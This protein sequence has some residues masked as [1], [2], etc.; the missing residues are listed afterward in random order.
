MAAGFTVKRD[1]FAKFKKAFLGWARSELDDAALV[2]R[3]QLDAEVDLASLDLEFLAQHDLFQPFG[4]GNAQPLLFAR[5]VSP[6]GETRVLK[7]KHLSFVASASRTGRASAGRCRAIFFD[8]ARHP[9]PAP[10]WDVAF[11]VERN[12]YQGNVSVQMVIQAIRAAQ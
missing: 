12:E 7:E 9:L 1:Q 10:P 3:L 11:R 2:P 4:I 5:N 6:L 8:G